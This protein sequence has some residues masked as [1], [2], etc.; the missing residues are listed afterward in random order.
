MD[1]I[2]ITDEWP[3]LPDISQELWDKCA[4]AK[5]FGEV[6]YEY[7]K[8]FGII[9]AILGALNPESPALKRIP[10][11]HFAVL[12]G[13]ILKMAKHIH[14]NMFLCT[15]DSFGETTALIDRSIAES[16]IKIQWLC[17]KNDRESFVRYLADGLKKDLKFKTQIMANITA[18]KGIT[19][20]I[21][22]RMIRSV[23]NCVSTSELSEDQVREAKDLPDLFSMFRDIGLTDIHYSGIQRLGSH[24]IHGTWTDLIT[25]YIEKNTNGKFQPR[26]RF[27]PTHQNQLMSLTLLVSNSL[28][29]FLLYVGNDKQEM[30]TM[31]EPIN[32][33]V[34]RIRLILEELSK[35]DIQPV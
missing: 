25:F 26:G 9:C 24:R 30:I 11:V 16:A 17:K 13:L 32:E 6:L 31:L 33:A 14:A 19:Q 29:D 4:R 34:S 22:R 3:P 20:A 23:D 7:Y 21:E 12:T 5:D 18:Q 35:D 2:P 8:Y 27:F 1:S 10:P 15:K 28:R